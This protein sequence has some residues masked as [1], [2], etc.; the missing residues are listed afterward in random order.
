MK[1]QTNLKGR[2]RNTTLPKNRAL[3][4]LFEAVINSIQSIEDSSADM[5][6][7]ITIEVIRE[8]QQTR[9]QTE[10]ILEAETHW[11]T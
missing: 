6:G 9:I 11:K 8:A 3:F 4:P 7:Q 10:K 1:L 5:S 2:L